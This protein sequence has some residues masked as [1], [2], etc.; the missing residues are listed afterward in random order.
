MRKILTV[1]F[2]FIAATSADGT[3]L[4]PCFT[5]GSDCTALTVRI[6]NGAKTEL[7]KPVSLI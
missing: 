4:T 1:L 2:A 6:L 5:P 3:T 7:L